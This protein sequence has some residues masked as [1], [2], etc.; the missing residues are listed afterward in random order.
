MNVLIT[1][2]T[3]FI[4]GAL[5]AHLC[6]LEAEITVYTRDPSHFD[7][8]AIRY[9]TSLDEI[10]DSAHFDAFIN[11][12]GESL[13]ARRWDEARKAV[14]VESRVGTTRSLVALAE[15]LQ[16][17]PAV[18]LSASAIGVYGHHGDERLGEDAEQGDGF[19]HRLCLAWETEAQRFDALG[20]RVCL[21]RLG[22]VLAADGGAMDQLRRSVAFGVGTWMGSGKQ[23]LSWVHRED[24]VAAIDFLLQHE[25]CEGPY[26]ITA[27]E[28]ITNRG[29]CDELSLRRQVFIKLPI[30]AAVMRL[31]L[32]EMAQELLLNG[33]RVVPARLQEAGFQF[34]YKNLREALAAL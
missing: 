34:R 15:R 26:N 4:G 10:D 16:V 28:P 11:L 32:G 3:G 18:V 21:L 31:A 33:Q 14:L 7:T 19:A 12:A 1:G 27:P 25:S 22:V 23:W 24:V 30:P 2:G 13:A 5:V 29:L 6:Q 9:I 8:E 17:K 20:I